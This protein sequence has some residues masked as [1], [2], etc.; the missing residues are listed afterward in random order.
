MARKIWSLVAL[1]SAASIAGCGQGEVSFAND[2]KPLLDA[3]CI[4]CHNPS[5][6]GQH[7]SA[8]N[9]ADYADIMKGTQFGPVVVPG[10]S[11]SSVLYMVVAG[12]TDPA[13]RMPPHHEESLAEGRGEPLSDAE[14]AMLAKWIDQGAKN[15]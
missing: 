6:E 13:I 11:I 5:G 3:R 8:L 4:G 1:A 9:L 14:I 7:A 2:V 15:N 12:K 10:S